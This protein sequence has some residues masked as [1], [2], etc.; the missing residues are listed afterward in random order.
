MCSMSLKVLRKIRSRV[1]FH[2]GLLPVVLPGLGHLPRG[3]IGSKV[4]RAHVQRAHLRLGLQRIRQPL[5]ERHARAAAGGDVDG[6]VGAL[7]DARQELA[8]TSGSGRS[9]PSR[10]AGVQMQDRRAGLG[11]RDR[12]L[13]AIWSG[14]SARCSDM[15]GVWTEPV[16]AQE[17][18]TLSWMLAMSYAVG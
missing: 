1:R 12:L 3:R 2:V 11:R 4:H 17:M 8:N 5:L 9:R 6:R 18:M 7:L 13:E 10:V 15:V 14:V 16:T